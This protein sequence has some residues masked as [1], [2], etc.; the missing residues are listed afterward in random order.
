MKSIFLLSLQIQYLCRVVV[1]FFGPT[2]ISSLVKKHSPESICHSL[3]ICFMEDPSQPLCALFH[4]Q[5]DKNRDRS[6]KKSGSKSPSPPQYR[7]FYQSVAV[8]RRSFHARAVSLGLVTPHDLGEKVFKHENANWWWSIQTQ[9]FMFQIMIC[10]FECRL[11]NLRSSLHT[12]V[13]W[14]VEENFSPP[15][16]GQRWRRR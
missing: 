4:K 10:L 14:R 16:D 9:N 12:A 3:R 11:V 8:N 1:E 13:L 7:E 2:I 6:A 5:H 15:R